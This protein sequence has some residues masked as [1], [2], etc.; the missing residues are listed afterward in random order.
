MIGSDIF[1]LVIGTAEIEDGISSEHV[2]ARGLVF[3]VG[4]PVAKK[5]SRR[6]TNWSHEEDQYLRKNI[7]W[8]SEGEMAKHLGRTVVAVHIRWKRDLMLTAPSKHP[9]FITG[10]QA[11]R[12]IGIDMHKISH[13][14]DVGLI[15]YRN[16]ACN[17]KM[18]LIYRTTFYRWVITPAN[19]IYFNWKEIPDQRLRRL[20][21]LRAERWGDE[22]WSTPEVAKYHGVE[23]GDVKRLIY[24]GEIPA[25]QV[26]TSLG[27]RHK[28]P[29]WLNW[30][31]LKSDAVKAKF[32]KR[33]KQNLF[34]L[35]PRGAAWA[36]KARY[37]LNMPWAVINRTMGNKTSTDPL[38]YAILRLRG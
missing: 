15:P 19:W 5:T 11:A 13:W 7:G 1:D 3:T 26:A 12:M 6:S 38:K 14:C 17:R 18:R 24:R 20:C 8:I 33:G 28:N 35:T 29:G 32:I 37:E 30:Y 22:W 2:A 16:M 23:T 9:D 25:T 31:V 4:A 21:E 36:L 34:S 10:L 27:G